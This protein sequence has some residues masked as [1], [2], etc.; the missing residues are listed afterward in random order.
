MIKYLVGLLGEV[1]EFRHKSR[2]Y[3]TAKTQIEENCAIIRLDVGISLSYA[4]GKHCKLSLRLRQGKRNMRHALLGE[5]TATSGTFFFCFEFLRDRG[6]MLGV[7]AISWHILSGNLC[8][9]W[10]SGTILVLGPW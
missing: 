10:C 1:V 7:A 8:G 6:I 9:V 4:R 2:C 3:D 5:A